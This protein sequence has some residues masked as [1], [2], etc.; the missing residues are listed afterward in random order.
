MPFACQQMGTKMQKPL[1]LLVGVIGFEPTTPSSRTRRPLSKSLINRAISNVK[2][3]NGART[4]GYFR[5]V[6]VPSG[7]TS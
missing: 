1:V 2:P 5:A 3:V 7:A 6:S 4:F